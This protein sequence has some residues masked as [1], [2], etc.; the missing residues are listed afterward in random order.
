[1]Y[2]RNGQFSG[3]VIA[4]AT[5]FVLIGSFSALAATQSVGGEERSAIFTAASK[6]PTRD[7]IAFRLQTIT[8]PIRVVA[9]RSRVTAV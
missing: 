4:V 7:A 2:S 8:A 5:V 9:C 1:M 3:R 6:L